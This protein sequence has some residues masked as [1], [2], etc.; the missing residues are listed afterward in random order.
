MCYPNAFGEIFCN[1]CSFSFLAAPLVANDAGAACMN[2]LMSK[3]ESRY[4]PKT[5]FCS[6]E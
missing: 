4:G 1:V 2:V 3:G 6:W 5:A